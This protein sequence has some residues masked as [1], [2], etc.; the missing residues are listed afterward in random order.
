MGENI[1]KLCIQQRN[2]IQNLQ[3]IQMSKKQI[4]PSK[5]GLRP[6]EKKSL[7][8]KGIYMHAA[9]L[10]TAKIRNQ[11][12]CLLT[13]EWTKKMHIYT[14]EYYTTAKN[15]TMSSVAT[16]MELEARTGKPNTGLTLLPRLEYSVVIV[17]HSL[18]PQPP[19][20]KVSLLCP[21]WSAVVRSQFTATSTSQVQGW[22]YRHEPP[23][24]AGSISFST[25]GSS[26]ELETSLDDRDETLSLLKIQKLAGSGDLLLQSQLVRRLKWED[27]LNP[28]DSLALSTRLEYNGVISAHCNLCLLGSSNSPALASQV[29]GTTGACRHARLIFVF[30]V[31]TGFHYVSQAGLKL[32]TSGDPA[33]SASRSAGITG[34]KWKGKVEQ[35]EADQECIY[36]NSAIHSTYSGSHSAPRLECS[37]TI[38]AHCSLDLP[39]LSLPRSWDYSMCHHAR[40]IFVFLEEK[41]FHHI[42][43]AGFELL[44]SFHQDRDEAMEKMK[45]KLQFNLKFPLHVTFIILFYLKEQENLDWEIPGKG[46]TW[47]TSVTLLAGA[48]AQRFSVW[49]IRDWVPF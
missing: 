48:P 39:G 20:L 18:Q 31:E 23:R 49:S 13:N 44:I 29:A 4:I 21:G 15:E 10:T 8:Q 9:Q 16:G 37:S 25:T 17:A 28:G 33:A 45:S 3:G 22:D 24:L 43:Q 36:R 42:G 19:G 5:S 41:G 35:H 26:N 11:P 27:G 6:E 47:V 14:M 7:Y 2:N 1:C 32:L 40:L 12:K 34:N 30:L 46:A 38:M